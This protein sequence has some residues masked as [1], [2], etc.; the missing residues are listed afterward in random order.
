MA[1]SERKPLLCGPVR[2][3]ADGLGIRWR[4]LVLHGELGR[5]KMVTARRKMNSEHKR[6]RLYIYKMI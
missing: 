4:K 5:R 1:H 6:K 3:D 2:S